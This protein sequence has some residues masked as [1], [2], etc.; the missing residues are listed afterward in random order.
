MESSKASDFL[1]YLTYNQERQYKL[2]LINEADTINRS[3]VTANRSIADDCKDSSIMYAMVHS[4]ILG[5]N[6][7]FI[8]TKVENIG[9]TI[10]LADDTSSDWYLGTAVN[11]NNRV[12]LSKD[13]GFIWSLKPIGDYFCITEAESN[14]S[15]TSRSTE[16]IRDAFSNYMYLT[17]DAMSG[18]LWDIQVKT[19]VVVK[20]IMA[21]PIPKK[22]KRQ[23][24]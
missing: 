22:F 2:I 23:L 10:K 12:I 9:F 13:K 14:L 20:P 17:H 7:T 21:G 16:F 24:S 8:F 18:C 1:E 5:N 4:N 6:S 3:I 15:L 19:D 11:E